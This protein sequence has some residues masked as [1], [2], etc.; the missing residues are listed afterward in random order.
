MQEYNILIPVISG[1]F[2]TIIGFATTFF[3]VWWTAKNKEKIAREYRKRQSLK[4]IYEVFIN[5]HYE[6]IEMLAKCTNK[7][8]FFKTFTLSPPKSIPS[9]KTA[10]M[11]VKL[12]GSDFTKLW[13]KFE[14]SKNDF[15]VNVIKIMQTEYRNK[16]QIHR[17]E[18]N[19][20]NVNY[21]KEMQ[22][23]IEDIH[24]TITQIIPK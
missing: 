4:D 11:L 10:E 12:Y 5:I 20:A 18:E 14:K 22:D 13:G 9:V 8:C 7:I 3:T 19:K 6:Y 2:G 15:S 17:D 16:S 1:L 24:A 21:Y 23:V